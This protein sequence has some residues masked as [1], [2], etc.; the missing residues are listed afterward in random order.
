[1]AVPFR[2]ELFIGV[3]FNADPFDVAAV[4]I[5]SDLTSRC[6]AISS[7]S[8]GRQYELDQN[9]TGALSA[10]WHD[11][12]EALNPNNT[13]SPYSPNVVP[14]RQILTRCMWPNGGTGNLLNLPYNGTDPTF[15]SYAD[16]TVLSWIS[17]TGSGVAPKVLTGSNF[18]GTKALAYSVFAGG[19]V[20]GVRWTVPC[21][22]GRQYTSSAYFIQQNANTTT[23]AVTGGPAGTSTAATGT[24]VRLTVTFTAT[25]P[26]HQIAV[27]TA[28]PV[29]STC[30]LDAVQHEP[31]QVLNANPYAETG[32]APWTTRGSTLTRTATAPH[33]GSW[34]FRVTPDGV[35]AVVEIDSEVVPA[36]VGAPTRVA[37]WFRCAVSRNITL[38]INWSNSVTGYL[39]TAVGPTVAL[40]ANVWT[41]AEFTA[42]GIASTTGAQAAHSMGGTP[43]ASNVLDADEMTIISP[44]PFITTGP[45]IRNIWT[46]GYVERWPS[47][48]V[49]SGFRGVSL[50]PCV[51]PFAI[52][53]NAD[54][55]PEAAG[56]ILAKVPTYLWKLQEP[57]GA[58]TFAESS[59]N[60]GP[61]LVR[62]NG[63]YGPCTTFEPGAAMNIAGDPSGVG[64]HMEAPQVGLPPTSMLS[65]GYQRATPVIALGSATMPYSITASLWATRTATVMSATHLMFAAQPDSTRPLFY[66]RLSPGT[67]G[68]VSFGNEFSIAVSTTD[69]WDDGLPHLYTVVLAVTSSGNTITGYVDGVQVATDSNSTVSATPVTT[70]TGVGGYM[71]PGGPQAFPCPPGGV[72]AY[73]ALWNRALSAAEIADMAAAGRG[74]AGETEGARIARHLALGGYTGPASIQAGASVMGPS[75]VKE[76]DAVLATCQRSA[77]SAFGNFYE[78]AD[79]A[80]Y[81]NRNARYLATTSSYTFGERVDLG[82]YPYEDDVSYDTDPQL[83]LNIADVERSGGV[84]A[85]A[86]DT[87][88]ASQK[89]YGKK[90]FTRTIDIAS[91][92]ET[93]DAATWTVSNRKDPLTRVA[94]ITFN[95]AA[96]E[97]PFGDGTLWPMVLTLEIGTRVTVKRRPKAGN[98]GSGLTMSGDFFVEAISHHDIVFA[99]GTWLTT[100]L[101]SPVNRAQPWILE[102]A[103]YG[104]LGSTTILGF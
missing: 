25:Q 58:I 35:T 44:S 60:N 33:E 11:T 3:A 59:G 8:R 26:T 29:T 46:R 76:G 63:P 85:H 78:S 92:N 84:K 91:D 81:A 100:L 10:L 9:Q 7:A 13:S 32:T 34:S 4:P 69:K 103:T 38:N 15:D 43:P 39:D 53:A 77:D 73:Y 16:N 27:T 18:Q 102:H 28:V 48:W 104:V 90:N 93:Q 79:G 96:V 17:P 36:A 65:T 55:H 80:A 94:A 71:Q 89:R 30:N 67:P 88:G 51:G 64:V 68:L 74:Y 98:G 86:E 31:S 52:L 14:Y 57:S 6:Y 12:D 72:Y 37:G 45:L 56:S 70:M 24:Y 19:G 95:P 22:P 87:T 82:E 5:W 1:M 61:P 75:T 66:V 50:T 40:T 54:L 2:P 42:Y 49:D 83:V 97:V 23:I 20:S 41:F 101:L 62:Q 21:I 47:Q 99:A